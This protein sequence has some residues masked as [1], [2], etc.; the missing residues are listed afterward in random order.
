MKKEGQPRL[1]LEREE[2]LDA[3]DMQVNMLD[4][5][6]AKLEARKLGLIRLRTNLVKE[7]SKGRIIRYYEDN[8]ELV[9]T[10]QPKP[11]LGFKT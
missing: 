11:P 7:E 2:F 3:I 6:I 9:F 5:T 1:Q 4:K 8:G 10:S